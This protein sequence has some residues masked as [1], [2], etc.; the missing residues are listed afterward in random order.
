[1]VSKILI[2]LGVVI[3]AVVVPF[4]EINSSHVF[5]PSWPAHARFHE[6]WQLTTNF[7]IGIVALWLAFNKNSI[8][9]ASILN[10]VVMGGALVAH[11]L[12]KSYGGSIISGNTG[13]IILGMELAAFAASVVVVLA[14]TAL[15]LAS[16][17]QVSPKDS[18]YIS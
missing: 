10:I 5:N 16:R 7:F 3:Y 6:V 2:A 11:V 8:R 17:P 13:I 12:E 18:E 1:M 15:F 4:L 14:I 9:I